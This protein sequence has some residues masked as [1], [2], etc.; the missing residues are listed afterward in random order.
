VYRA[1]DGQ[2]QVIDVYVSPQRAAE[3]AAT[4]FRQAIEATGVVPDEVATDCAPAYPPALSAVLPGALQETGKAIQ[5]RIGRDHQHLKGRLSAT[6]GFKTLVGARVLCAGHAFLR[7]LL[8]SF[9]DLGRR[10]GAAD[11][12]PVPSLPQAWT[13]LT[14]LLLGR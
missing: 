9:Y 12:A 7:N 4:F 3:D 2:G 6:R 8:G 1:I 13:T 11:R 14:S 5:Q 10:V